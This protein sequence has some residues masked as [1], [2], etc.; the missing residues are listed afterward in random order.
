MTC[1]VRRRPRPAC[2]WSLF[3]RPGAPMRSMASGEGTSMCCTSTHANPA[4]TSPH[5]KASFLSDMPSSLLQQSL[6]ARHQKRSEEVL[7][8]LHR[9][10]AWTGQTYSASCPFHSLR[11]CL[12]T[13]TAHE[14]DAPP[15]IYIQHLGTL[16]DTMLLRES[17]PYLVL[18]PLKPANWDCLFCGAY[19]HPSRFRLF[20]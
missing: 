10:V 3:P 6:L 12:Q 20:V 11:S 13:R 4:S 17:T 7:Q 15:S 14:S 9:I 18:H 2:F 16:S 5:Q 19:L 1:P 8:Y